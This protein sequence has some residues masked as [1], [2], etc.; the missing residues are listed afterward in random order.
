MWSLPS[1][2]FPRQE[3]LLHTVSVNLGVEMSTRDHNA[4]GG[5]G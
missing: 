5:E 1:C 3:T 2:C 4:G